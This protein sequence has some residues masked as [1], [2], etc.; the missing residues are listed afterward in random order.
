MYGSRR[1]RRAQA[2]RS[3]TN[4][5]LPIKRILALYALGTT[6]VAI[7]LAIGNPYGGGNNR[8]VDVLIKAGVYR[9]HRANREYRGKH[10]AAR[11][12]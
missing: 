7:A 12:S 8:V 2:R 9:G 6:V 5:A 11:R 10:N 3:L 4:G 1:W